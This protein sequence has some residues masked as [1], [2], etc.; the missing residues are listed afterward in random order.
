MICFDNIIFEL[1]NRGGISR[2]WGE[3]IKRYA[4][5]GYGPS[6][7]IEN[8]IS[9]VNEIRKTIALA[10]NSIVQDRV[11]LPL[12]MRRYLPVN[13]H[14]KGVTVFHSS[15]Y[16]I[17]ANKGIA[18]I[19]TVHDLIYEYYGRGLRSSIHRRQKALALKKSVKVI[20]VSEN[21][22][23]DV[24]RF[25]PDIDRKK[26]IV[27]PLAA[28]REYNMEISENETI[29]RQMPKGPFVIY[30]GKRGGYKNFVILLRALN[31]L[32]SDL[33][34]TMHM[35]VVGGER[36]FSGDEIKYINENDLSSQ[37]HKLDD[38]D[39]DGLNCIYKKALALII[40]SKYEGFGLTL[41]EAQQA[42]CP[43]IS[44]RTSSLSEI[45]SDDNVLF[46]EPDKINSLT[47][48][49]ARI[50][51]SEIS[52]GLKLNGLK[53]AARFSWDK[54]FKLTKDIYDKL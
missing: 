26:I 30:V 22:A 3:I 17:A 24:L 50:S 31:G 6:I 19:T 8:S 11:F 13:I 51:G 44:S 4:G 32:R 10:A 7:F 29:G 45:G 14:Q 12:F 23:N 2:Y 49:I 27:I 42:G 21:T 20:A 33:R 36:G 16:R 39:D 35:M 41:L 38:I 40:T 25:Y 47:E 18:N 5:A 28:S 9:T 52:K 53:N 15:Y 1:Q 37:I 48:A 54:T 46:Y 34:K 43:V